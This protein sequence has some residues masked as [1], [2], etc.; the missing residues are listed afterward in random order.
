MWC[1]REIRHPE[2]HEWIQ[3]S[4]VLLVLW[5]SQQRSRHRRVAKCLSGAVSRLFGSR[6]YTMGTQVYMAADHVQSPLLP[7]TSRSWVRAGCRAA[8]GAAVWT[9]LEGGS[10]LRPSSR[11]PIK[12]WLSILFSEQRWEAFT[13]SFANITLLFSL[14]G[15]AGTGITALCSAGLF[16]LRRWFLSS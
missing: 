5:L 10:R 14:S 7:V 9:C 1:S 13:G 16:S 3:P 8:P 4:C 2:G 15:T 6:P 12:G 11:S